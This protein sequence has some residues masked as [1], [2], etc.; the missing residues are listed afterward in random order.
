ME[1]AKQRPLNFAIFGHSLVWFTRYNFSPLLQAR[2]DEIVEKV[3]TSKAPFY[4]YAANQVVAALVRKEIPLRPECD[5]WIRCGNISDQ[6]W[7]LLEKCW[8]YI[9]ENRPSCQ[10][11]RDCITI[12]G[13]RDTRSA[14]T[15]NTETNPA[16]W[17]DMAGGSG[18]KI[19]YGRVQE[20]LRHV[21]T[22][23]YLPSRNLTHSF[24]SVTQKDV[25]QVHSD[26]SS[27]GSA[28][29]FSEGAYSRPPSCTQLM[30][31]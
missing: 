20:I 22:K 26:T 27:I 5:P 21:S 8:D 3:L 17:E 29:S 1:I 24:Q 10:E 11:I 16:P 18:V 13:F 19:D 12:M 14:T 23:Q 25:A 30:S 28:H 15:A 9:P 7:E 31:S 2:T 4:Q 6:L